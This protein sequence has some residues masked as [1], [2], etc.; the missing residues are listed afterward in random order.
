MIDK[1][2]KIIQRL[3]DSG[4]TILIIEHNLDLIKIAD[5]IIDLGPE[6]GNAGGG[7][8]DKDSVIKIRHHRAD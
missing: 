7:K 2:I 4:N 1:L 8:A 6:G 5:Y 3:A